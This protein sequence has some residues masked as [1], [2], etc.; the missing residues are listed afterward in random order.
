MRKMNRFH[1]KR[2]FFYKRGPDIYLYQA[3]V[4]GGDN[5]SVEVWAFGE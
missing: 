1:K 2:V 5:G 4:S 3:S